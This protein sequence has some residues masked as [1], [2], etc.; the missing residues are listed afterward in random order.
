MVYIYYIHSILLFT[1]LVTCQKK[2]SKICLAWMIFNK[3]MLAST[4]NFS[5][6]TVSGSE[7]TSTCTLKCNPSDPSDLNN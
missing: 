5:I 6:I 1:K 4:N 7:I 2:S 3:P